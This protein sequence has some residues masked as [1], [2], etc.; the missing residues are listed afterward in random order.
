[1]LNTVTPGN[2]QRTLRILAALGVALAAGAL[3]VLGAQPIAV[4][5]IPAPWDKLAHLFV[6]AIVGAAAG[7]ASGKRGWRMTLYCV[8]GAML[9]GAMDELH[10]AFLP[11][12]AASWSDLAAD[13]TGGFLGAGVLGAAYRFADGRVKH[14]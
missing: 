10:Q 7:V 11:G 9:V 8:A 4:G 13:L 5:L 12:R 2:F 1:M 3:Y 6:F 14:R